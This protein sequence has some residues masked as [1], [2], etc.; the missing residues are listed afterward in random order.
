[1]SQLALAAEAGTTARHLSFVETGRSRPGRELLRRLGAALDVPPRE[2]NALLVAAGLAP[3]FPDRELADEAMEPVRRVLDRILRTHEP[4]PAWVVGRGLRF[5][6]SNGGAEALFPG[7]CALAPEAIVDLWYGPGPLRD[8]VENWQD[9][10]RAGVA[11]LRREAA[12]T[13]DAEL[14]GLWRRA[15][16]HV[17]GAP[18]PLVDGQEDLP[19]VCAR[20][21]IGARTVRTVS[22]VL[23]FDGAVDVTASDLR[24]ELMFPADAESDAFFT[25]G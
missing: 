20:L 6:A 2:Q 12:R 24:V 8:L 13:A 11:A 18:A 4:Y 17:R 21:R 15:E 25:G 3:A 5:L 1:M 23:R 19:F 10:A 7:M 16:A 22:T 9:V 14:L